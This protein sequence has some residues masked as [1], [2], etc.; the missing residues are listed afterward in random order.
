MAKQLRKPSLFPGALSIWSSKMFN[1][2]R[3]LLPISLMLSL[4]ISACGFTPVYKYTGTENNLRLQSLSVTGTVIDRSMARE[5]KR[6]ISIGAPSKIGASIDVSR[7]V[8]EMQKDSDGIA[9]RYAVTH[10]AKLS[11]QTGDQ[12]ELETFRLTQYMTRGDSAADELTQLRN[13]DDL[14]SRDLTAQILAFM[15]LQI[16]EADGR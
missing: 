9:R 2:R 15:S 3:I 13:L 7:Q 14:A 16:K 12:A 11:L 6:H 1:G 10:T 5:L 8:V 4:A